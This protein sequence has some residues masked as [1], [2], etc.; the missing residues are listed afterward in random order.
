MRRFPPPQAP[1]NRPAEPDQ[2]PRPAAFRAD[3]NTLS[4][5]EVQSEDDD[6]LPSAESSCADLFDQKAHGRCTIQ[7]ASC[8]QNDAEVRVSFRGTKQSRVTTPEGAQAGIAAES[9]AVPG[10][11]AR[12]GKTGAVGDCL[13]QHIIRAP[14]CRRLWP[15]NP[16][17]NGYPGSSSDK[18]EQRPLVDPGERQVNVLQGARRQQ[19]RLAPLNNGGDDVR[20]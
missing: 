9:G 5:N 16:D 3:S 14:K 17:C 8:C 18:A 20:R 4:G 2:P 1:R 10:D 7:D 15:T 13:D 11:F 19:G 6:S 12:V